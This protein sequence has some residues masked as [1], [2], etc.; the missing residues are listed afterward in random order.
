MRYSLFQ[1]E[2][3]DLLGI[4]PG[5]LGGWES[6]KHKQPIKKLQKVITADFKILNYHK[7][8]SYY[9]EIIFHLTNKWRWKLNL[10]L[11]IVCSNHKITTYRLGRL[12]N[13]F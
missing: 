11:Y 9:F 7:A 8:F 13:N 6:G 1:K 2:L 12:T 3:E 10:P 4:D 5:S